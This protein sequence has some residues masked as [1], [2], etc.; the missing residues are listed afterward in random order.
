MNEVITK[1]YRKKSNL[2]WFND[3]Y[4]IAVYDQYDN[5]I[6]IFETIESIGTAFDIGLKKILEAIRN[7]TRLEYE[8]LKL[9]LFVYQKEKIKEEVRR[10]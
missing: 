3:N 7:N 9:R 2:D 8:N 10:R 6:N 1:D 5:C 4:F